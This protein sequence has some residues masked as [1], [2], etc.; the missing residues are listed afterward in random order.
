MLFQANLNKFNA[1]TRQACKVERSR[2]FFAKH[3][4]HILLCCS[5]HILCEPL[6]CHQH[7]RSSE[8]RLSAGGALLAAKLRQL[9]SRG[10]SLFYQDEATSKC[11]GLP[12][13]SCAE[14][15]ASFPSLFTV[16]GSFPGRLLVSIIP[17]KK[18]LHWASACSN[19]HAI[20][21]P[22]GHTNIEAFQ[23][24]QRLCA[25]YTILNLE[26]Y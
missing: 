26:C 9:Q 23:A 21:Q 20:A 7:L 25:V 6:A 1:G 3:S 11:I 19:T 18:I 24:L 14:S 22:W 5:E 8:A 2:A 16:V 15:V 13:S 17:S 4:I 12:R 10:Q